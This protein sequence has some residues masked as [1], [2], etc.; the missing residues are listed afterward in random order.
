MRSS[1]SGYGFDH[2]VSS[3]GL[4]AMSL[5]T[6][7]GEQMPGLTERQSSIEIDFDGPVLQDSQSGIECLAPHIQITLRYM[8]SE[9]YV[10]RE[11][12]GGSCPFV[13]K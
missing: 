4:N 5:H 10:A 11:F 12:A 3:R 8:P 6:C 2:T 1:Q 9:L 7:F 13:S